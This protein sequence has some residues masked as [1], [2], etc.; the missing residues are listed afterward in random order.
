M[1]W[2]GMLMPINWTTALLKKYPT[3]TKWRVENEQGPLY[4]DVQ[5][6]KT[7]RV[8]IHPER[9]IWRYHYLPF[10][11]SDLNGF[12]PNCHVWVTFHAA[13]HAYDLTINTGS[14]RYAITSSG[15]E[16]LNPGDSKEVQFD[17]ISFDLPVPKEVQEAKPKRN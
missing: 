13:N 14:A 1:G 16:L 12:F 9:L 10:T 8:N 6:I 2:L 11:L 17:Q 4:I 7:E 5:R 3:L 15:T